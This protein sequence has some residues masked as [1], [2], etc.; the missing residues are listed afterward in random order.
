MARVLESTR[1]IARILGPFLVVAGAAAVLR[2]DELLGLI[3]SFQADPA[4]T[5]VTG[6][7]LLLAGLA[8]MAVHQ[9]WRTPAEIVLSLTI[10]LLTLRGVFLLF[11]PAVLFDLA[12]N[13]MAQT[14]LVVASG[15]AAVG[16]GVWLTLVGYRRAA[17]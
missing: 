2:R 7:L 16:V 15:L 10:W 8:L 11:A 6:M 3:E 5:F 9:T 14:P 17:G 12:D 1:L 4:L 13:V